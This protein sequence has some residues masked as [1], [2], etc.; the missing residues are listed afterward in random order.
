MSYVNSGNV[1]GTTG[2]NKRMEATQIQ[3]G[4]P[5]VLTIYD[6][7]GCLCFNSTANMYIY[8]QAHIE[9]MGWMGWVSEGN[10]AGTTGAHLRIEALQIRAYLIKQ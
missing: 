8:Y 4:G 3:I 2:Q 1:A 6:D 7:G 5:R 10:I 9:D